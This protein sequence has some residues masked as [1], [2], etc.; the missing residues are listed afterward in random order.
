MIKNSILE[1]IGNTPLIK[2]SKLSKKYHFS[3]YA[4]YELHNPAGSI[5][6]RTALNIMKN[7]LSKNLINKTTTIIESSSGNMAVALAMICN[8]YNLKFIAIVDIKTTKQNIDI[9]KSYNG[10]VIL[11][12]KEDFKTGTLL[13]A[14]LNKVSE[15]LSMN[16]DFFWINQYDNLYN[17][18]AHYK[19]MEEIDFALNKKVDYLFSAV[20]TC[21]TITGC[22]NYIK[23]N[24]RN[25]KLIAVDA[26]GSVIFNKKPSKRLIPGHG[27]GIV[28]KNLN[29][30]LITD[31]VHIS[32]EDCINGCSELLNYESIFAGG[33]SGAVVSAI[34][35]YKNN[36]KENSIV[37]II[38]ADRGDRY[39]DT[40]YN[41]KWKEN[42]FKTKE[43]TQ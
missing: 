2:L 4:K 29:K 9:I 25:T 19:T 20:S 35:K 24:N 5:K 36:I 38:L 33:S 41:D 39:I 22:G 14:R 16:E 7:L 18:D 32:D 31:I 37:V 26:K 13:S 15:L 3:I 8:N 11:I 21:G 28:P 30:E 6:D 17:I 34:E 27:A 43:Q 1:I 42:N 10:E 12:D 40:I 23:E